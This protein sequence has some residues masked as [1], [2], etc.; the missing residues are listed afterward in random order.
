MTTSAAQLRAVASALTPEAFDSRDW[1]M[2]CDLANALDLTTGLMVWQAV[3][4]GN[5]A[6]WRAVSL[7]LELEAYRIE[8]AEERARYGV[9][10][11]D[12]HMAAVVR[13]HWAKEA[14]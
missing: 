6:L 8:D 3:C 14:R 2:L 1:H 5:M 10:Y 11:P 12:Y 7:V 13:A 9:G 4:H